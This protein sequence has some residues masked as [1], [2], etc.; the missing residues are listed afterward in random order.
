MFAPFNRIS[1]RDSIAGSMAMRMPAIRYLF[2]FEWALNGLNRQSWLTLL[3]WKNPALYSRFGLIKEKGD[4]LDDF[5]FVEL[6][7]K[8]VLV[9]KRILGVHEITVLYYLL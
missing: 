7:Y 5:L 3:P 9:S 1:F 8:I 6:C 4:S 2:S